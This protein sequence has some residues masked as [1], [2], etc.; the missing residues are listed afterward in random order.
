MTIKILG[1]IEK[2]KCMSC[3]IECF[4]I[5]IETFVHGFS[6]D[7]KEVKWK[8]NCNKCHA[9]WTRINNYKKEIVS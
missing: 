5:R 2:G 7:L 6:S 9:N 3:G 1:E 4:R 8:Y